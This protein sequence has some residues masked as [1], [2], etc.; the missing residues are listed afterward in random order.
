[1]IPGYGRMPCS[2]AQSQSHERFLFLFD[3]V[4][5]Y[6]KKTGTQLAR[7]ASVRRPRSIMVRAVSRASMEE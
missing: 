4:L 3:N 1:M 6:C 2:L 5:I 7:K